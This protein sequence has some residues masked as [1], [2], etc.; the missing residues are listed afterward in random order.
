MIGNFHMKFFTISILL[1]ICSLSISA[2]GV[3]MR[4]GK[5]QKMIAIPLQTGLEFSLHSDSILSVKFEDDG[6]LTGYTDSSL[7]IDE[8]REIELD[9]FIYI[10][11]LPKR[12]KKARAVARPFIIGGFGSF[13]RG[14]LMMFGE[15][16]EGTNKQQAPLWIGAGGVVT[17][18]SAIPFMGRKKKFDIQSGDW[19][20]II[21]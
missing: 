1:T 7:I 8:S 4:N 6:I 9:D 10:N 18:V 5:S 20:I 2:Q 11:S 14:V 19:E 3:K 13:L 15:G 21:E 12:N 16:L 17:T